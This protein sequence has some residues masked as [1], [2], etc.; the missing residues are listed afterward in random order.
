MKTIFR[1]LM[2][3]VITSL[4]LFI[5]ACK[6]DNPPTPPTPDNDS[7]T[8][9]TITQNDERQLIGYCGNNIDVNIAAGQM[10]RMGGGTTLPKAMFG[11]SKY[12]VGARVYIGAEAT[13]TKIFI[14][15]NLQTN[16]YEQPFEVVPNAWNYVKFTT[17]FE[18]NDSLPGV[19]IGYIGMSDGAMLGMESGEFQ[20]NSGGMGMDIY[21]DSTEDDQWQFFTKVGGYGYKGKLGV[22]AVV[23]GG[24]YSADTQNDICIA[25]PRIDAKLPINT[26]NTI[27]FD[28]FNYGI[29][30]VNDITV[31]YE[32]NGTKGSKTFNNLDLWKGMGHSILITDLKTPATESKQ[33]LTIT[34]I[35]A[36]GDQKQDDNKYSIE[37]EIYASGFPRKVLIEKFTSQACSACPN[38]AEIVK[39]TR[40]AFEGRSIEVAHHEGYGPDAFTIDQSVTYTKFFFNQPKFGPA[41]MIDRSLDN[42]E[43]DTSVVG[44]INDDTTP[45][46]TE[47]VLSKAL[48]SISPLNVNISHTYNEATRL[49]TVTVSGEA[50]QQLPNA[51]VNVWLT[52]SN[53]KASQTKGGND[54][55]HNHAIRAT[56]TDTWGQE[57]VLTP[58][59]KYE[60]TFR[61]E[62]PEKIGNF[63]IV[64]EDME[65]V[66]FVAD[67][68]ATNNFNCRVHNAEAVALK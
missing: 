1:N 2:S 11:D 49:L 42:S 23:A 33:T 26:T 54:Y 9:P 57:L 52:Q 12:I 63:D 64:V 62:L 3:L 35:S 34:A 14:S 32:Y 50:I 21:Y 41:I 60:M 13:D 37:Q 7:T 51:R 59:N 16:L 10:A 6:P 36:N 38:G 15:A 19:Y 27:K 8:T 30:I 17:P 65:I 25:N 55:S 58:D 39:T 43:N 20:L 4:V 24:D 5:S 29:K 53:I 31:E 67:Y 48:E 28:V 46:F 61:Y 66:A 45:L 68:D 56:L 22:Q 47:A 40:A 18:L 44:R